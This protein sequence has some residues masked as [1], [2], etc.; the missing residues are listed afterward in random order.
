MSEAATLPRHGRGAL[1]ALRRLATHPWLAF[2]LRLYIGGTFVYASVYKI[3]YP[4]EFAGSIA[5]YELVPHWAV[6][7]MAVAMPWLE[8]VCGLLTIVGVRPKASILTLMGLMALFALAVAITL[9]RG[10]PI[11]CGCFQTLEDQISWRTL[12]RDL[13]WLGMTVHIYRY[14]CKLHLEKLF[15]AKIKEL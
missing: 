1:D 15:L 13:I 5:S 7:L 9:A 6:G 11:G 2:L 3:N 8:L 14:D 12:V 10:V 4:A